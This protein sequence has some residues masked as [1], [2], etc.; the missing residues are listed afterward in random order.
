M[1]PISDDAV[2]LN[3]LDYSETSQVMVFFTREHGKLRAIGKGTRRGTKTRFASGIDLLEI[4][5]L[6]CSAKPDRGPT[7]STLMEWKQTRPLSGLRDKLGRLYGAQ[8][9]AEITSHLTE[10][11]DP[12]PRTFEKLVDSLEVLA[13]AEDPLPVVVAYQLVLLDEIGSMPRLDAC[14]HCGRDADLTHFS[15]LDGGSVCRH[16]EPGQV[17]KREVAAATLKVLQAAEHG[18]E[19]SIA[20]GPFDVLNYHLSHLMA[21]EP[22]LASKLLPPERRRVIG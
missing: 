13:S 3:R 4:G 14:V 18:E 10:E 8:Y 20:V 5:R 12:H 22:L 6:V 9:L 2:V 15:A 17:E 19:V 16:C 11:W 7:L 1:P 21:R